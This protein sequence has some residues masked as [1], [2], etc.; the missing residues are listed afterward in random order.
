MESGCPEHIGFPRGNN[1]ALSMDSAIVDEDLQYLSPDEIRF[2]RE[3]YG[4]HAMEWPQL[5]A[6]VRDAIEAGAAPDSPEA[7]ALARR[8]LDLFRSYAGDDP[9]TQLKFRE[10]LQ[11]E[12]A[13]TKGAWV[14][15]TLLAFIREAMRHAVQP[16]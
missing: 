9:A 16:G 10:A 11:R 6:E 5:M 2:M 13:L 15:E 7:L 4:K 12:P 14:D 1:V 3:N 8:W